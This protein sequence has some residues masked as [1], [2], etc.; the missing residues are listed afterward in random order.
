MPIM[1][2]STRSL[3]QNASRG[4]DGVR[5]V[6]AAMARYPH[7]CASPATVNGCSETHTESLH[8]TNSPNARGRDWS[9]YSDPTSD[10]STCVAAGAG[11]ISCAA[12]VRPVLSLTPSPF[13]QQGAR[14]QSLI[15]LATGT[16]AAYE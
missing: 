13:Y 2:R 11:G 6:G 16:D 8:G 1:P 10:A 7:G 4:C 14:A 3:T 9:R 12:G 5:D 15:E